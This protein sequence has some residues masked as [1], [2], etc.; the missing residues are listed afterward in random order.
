[1]YTHTYSP[2]R[3]V[4]TESDSL[5]ALGP[6]LSVRWTENPRQSSWARF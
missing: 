5:H 6:V 3:A 2:D 4:F 1:M